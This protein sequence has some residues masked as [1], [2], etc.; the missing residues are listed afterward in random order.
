MGVFLDDSAASLSDFRIWISPIIGTRRYGPL[1]G[2]LLTPEGLG[3][4]PGKIKRLFML[5]CPVLGHF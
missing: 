2:L 3:L 1:R 4:W 5:F